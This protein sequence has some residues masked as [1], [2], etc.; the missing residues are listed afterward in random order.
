M[1]SNKKVLVFE[2]IGTLFIILLGGAFHF[3][4]ELSGKLAVVGAFS[5]VNESVWEHLKLA[6]WPSLLWLVIAYFPLRKLT[7]NYLT[8]KTIGT[9][10][11]VTIIPIVFYSYTS[12]VGESIFTIDIT[13]FILAVVIGQV[14]SYLLF[15]KNVFS[16]CVDKIAIVVLLAFAVAFVV[17]T[18]Y[19]P[20]I[21]VFQD[22]ISG[23]YGISV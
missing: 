8:A 10:M 4:Y 17:F 7:N 5:A 11:M 21:A 9:S 20:H 6:F 16:E 22:P 23:G 15:K 13:T 1:G 14:S 19:P 12:I 2:I 3:T 18:F